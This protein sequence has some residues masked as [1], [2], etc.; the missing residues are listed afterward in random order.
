M[1]IADV[2]QCSFS[3]HSFDVIYVRETI[4]Y[5]GDKTTLMTKFLVYLLSVSARHLCIN[6]LL[7]FTII[8]LSIHP[9]ICLSLFLFMI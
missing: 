1:Y 4:E 2:K 3:N 5:L 6:I 9:S 7:Q 8:Y